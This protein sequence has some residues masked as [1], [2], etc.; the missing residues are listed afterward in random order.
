MIEAVIALPVMITALIGIRYVHNLYAA[1]QQTMLDARRVAWTQALAGC[2][3]GPSATAT[4]A[5]AH[6]DLI[7]RYV[8]QTATHHDSGTLGEIPIVG[9]ALAD[10]ALPGTVGSAACTTQRPKLLDGGVDT[11]STDTYLA[12]NEPQRDAHQDA[13]DVFTGMV[14]DLLGL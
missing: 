1:K 13:M 7:A 4:G 9:G 5:R 3:A 8:S 11:L 12:C 2:D 6:G 14:G 10:L